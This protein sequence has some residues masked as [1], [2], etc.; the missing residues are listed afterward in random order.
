LD[1]ML[2]ATL[3]H[4]R[5]RVWSLGWH[6]QKSRMVNWWRHPN[7]SSSGSQACESVK[8]PY[9]VPSRVLYVQ[10]SFMSPDQCSMYN[11]LFTIYYAIVLITICNQTTISLCIPGPGTT[12]ALCR[13]SK[14]LFVPGQQSDFFRVYVLRIY[15]LQLLN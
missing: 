7:A 3:T 2:G 5:H 11:T 4:A 15:Y 12:C 9:R 6:H 1:C 8:A 13:R 10:C 14:S